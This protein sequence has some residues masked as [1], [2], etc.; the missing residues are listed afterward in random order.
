MD[1]VQC[2]WLRAKK[3]EAVECII[4]NGLG[5]IPEK[6]K[7]HLLFIDKRVK[8]TQEYYVQYILRKDAGATIERIHSDGNYCFQQDLASAHNA[9]CVH[10]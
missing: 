6:G 9:K 1:Y 8:I 7:L 5:D 10:A 4:C 3:P 2:Q